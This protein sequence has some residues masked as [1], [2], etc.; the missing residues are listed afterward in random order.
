MYYNVDW[1]LQIMAEYCHLAQ[2]IGSKTCQMMSESLLKV[3]KDCSKEKELSYQELTS[4][5]IAK[6]FCASSR[7]FAYLKKYSNMYCIKLQHDCVEVTLD[8]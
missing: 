3:S 1:W 2:C 6:S 8:T 5:T 7:H 4:N